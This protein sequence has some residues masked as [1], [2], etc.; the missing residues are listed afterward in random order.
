MDQKGQLGGEEVCH[1][2]SSLNLNEAL[3]RTF[4]K[5]GKKEGTANGFLTVNP[6]RYLMEFNAS[7]HSFQPLVTY[8]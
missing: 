1:Q 7:A 4:R 8:M 3:F 5:I 6:T 2:V